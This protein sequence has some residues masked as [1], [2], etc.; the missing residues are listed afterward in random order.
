MV[1]IHAN[2]LTVNKCKNIHK[3]IEV[4]T[5]FLPYVSNVILLYWNHAE[6]SQNWIF[7][8]SWTFLIFVPCIEFLHDAKE[9]HTINIQTCVKS[10]YPEVCSEHCC[11]VQAKTDL[12]AHPTQSSLHTKSW[13]CIIELVMISCAI[14]SINATQS[15]V[16]TGIETFI[17][18]MLPS[19]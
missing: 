14:S 6:V 9:L 12:G 7:M 13:L 4:K 1:T 11:L 19:C 10:W 15:L 8:F 17:K 18:R 3:V 16:L 5:L 2:D